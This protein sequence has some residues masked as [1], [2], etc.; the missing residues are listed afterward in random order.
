VKARPPQPPVAPKIE[1]KSELSAPP[2]AVSTT[3]ERIAALRQSLIT[4]RDVESERV[5]RI[6]TN[7][8]SSRDALLATLRGPAIDNE[9]IAAAAHGYTEHTAQLAHQREVQDESA[10]ESA[11]AV[12]TELAQHILH[13]AISNTGELQSELSE[14]SDAAWAEANGSGMASPVS[15]GC[16]TPSVD[17]ILRAE[18][19]EA[20]SAVAFESMQ[21]NAALSE[22]AVLKTAL[23]SE[24]E[25]YSYFNK[26][27]TTHLAELTAARDNNAE[28]FQYEETVLQHVRVELAACSSQT[29]AGTSNEYVKLTSEY[30]QAE[31]A[32]TALRAECNVYL[33]RADPLAYFLADLHRSH[34]A[35]EISGEEELKML[36]DF[37][38]KT[39]CTAAKVEDAEASHD[40]VKLRTP[41]CHQHNPMPTSYT[42]LICITILDF[43]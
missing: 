33:E 5:V 43:L 25:A 38:K 12:H 1:V 22:C 3:E 8:C 10:T 18:L 17:R 2:S 32:N 40:H 19:L 41:P 20:T 7:L 34:S 39:E 24:A 14:V 4:R 31:A 29:E 13:A 42:T 9:E 27:S 16:T 36:E 28:K 23:A 37:E 21:M 11:M 26:K 6:R 30:K 15:G 35:G